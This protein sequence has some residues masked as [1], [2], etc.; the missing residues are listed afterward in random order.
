MEGEHKYTLS[1]YMSLDQ[2]ENVQA[3][4]IWVDAQPKPIF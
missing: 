1:N 2:G 4:Y 3:M